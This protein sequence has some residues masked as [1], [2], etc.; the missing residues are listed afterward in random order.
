MCH[1]FPVE[2]SSDSPFGEKSMTTFNMPRILRQIRENRA[3]IPTTT[4]MGFCSNGELQGSLPL[5]WHT[6]KERQA[7]ASQLASHSSFW[8]R[9]ASFFFFLWLSNIRLLV[10]DSISCLGMPERD[11]THRE[12]PVLRRMPRREARRSAWWWRNP[13]EWLQ[14]RSGSQFLCHWKDTNA[15]RVALGPRLS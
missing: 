1:W 9:I 7:V 2:G 14:S 3:G 5:R 8:R 6:S 13:G 12:S 4:T 11:S 10:A 15:H